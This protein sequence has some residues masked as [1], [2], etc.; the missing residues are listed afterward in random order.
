[1]ATQYVCSFCG[2]QFKQVWRCR[3]CG[4]VVCDTCSKGGKS[5]MLGKLTRAYVGV[6]TLGL[7]EATRSGYRKIKQKC[8]SCDGK[9]LIII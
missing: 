5:S 2:G 8:P 6:S 3:N 7:S 4:T 1:M 9:D